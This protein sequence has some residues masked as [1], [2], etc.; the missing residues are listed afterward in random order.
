MRESLGSWDAGAGYSNVGADASELDGVVATVLVPVVVVALVV[1]LASDD[2]AA[3]AA[4]VW[5]AAREIA[6]TMSESL[7]MTRLLLVVLQSKEIQHE[8]SFLY[9][10]GQGHD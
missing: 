7:S 6:A 8:G 4:T 2:A 3:G 1:D 5:T 10:R 9:T